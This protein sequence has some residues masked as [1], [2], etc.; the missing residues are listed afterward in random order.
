MG[1]QS[2]EAKAEIDIHTV[3]AEA[4][5]KSVHY[6]LELCKHCAFYSWPILSSTIVFK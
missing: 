5:M 1:I 4:K 3:T 6:N 2:K